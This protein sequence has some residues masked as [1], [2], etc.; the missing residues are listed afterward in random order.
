MSLKLF[1]FAFVTSLLMHTP[2]HA[3]NDE[4]A[5]GQAAAP[6]PAAEAS[7]AMEEKIRLHRERFDQREL[8]RQAKKAQWD[9]KMRK[10]RAAMQK[11]SNKQMDARLT[12]LAKQQERIARRHEAMRND[13]QD[14]YNFLTRNSQAMLN[15]ML[16][17]QIEIANRHEELRK[18]AEERHRRIAAHRDAM[19]DMAPEERRLYME[20]HASEIFGL[21]ASSRRPSAPVRQPWM[22]RRQPPSPAALEADPDAMVK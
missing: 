11:F 4:A 17:E 12:M 3:E 10:R 1:V 7:G 15:K 6:G 8:Q 20:E 16:D 5:A 18:E 13:A 2:V 9:E 19:L 14:R 21:S 22:M